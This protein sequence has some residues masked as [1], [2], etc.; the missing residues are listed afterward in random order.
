[1]LKHALIEMGCQFGA[2]GSQQGDGRFNDSDGLG[3]QH[4]GS[5]SVLIIYKLIH[6]F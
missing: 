4:S 1:M 3:I 6:V 5:L 2:G